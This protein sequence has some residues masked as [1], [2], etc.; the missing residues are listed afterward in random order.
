[1]SYDWLARL[2]PAD[3]LRLLIFD[4]ELRRVPRPLISALWAGLDALERDKGSQV[5]ST[6]SGPSAPP[7]ANH[8]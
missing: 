6:G 1:M 3:R 2:S 8:Y 5:G 4:A 7:A